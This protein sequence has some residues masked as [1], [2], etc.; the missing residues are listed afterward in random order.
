MDAELI[1]YIADLLQIMHILVLR[2]RL[3]F[4]KLTAKENQDNAKHMQKGELV[5]K[6]VFLKAI[7]V[8]HYLII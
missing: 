2:M 6:E 7:A 5:S 3:Y 8:F 4:R 1:D